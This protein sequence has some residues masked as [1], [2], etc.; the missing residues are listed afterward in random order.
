LYVHPGFAE[1]KKAIEK[2]ARALVAQ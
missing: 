1:K 2:M